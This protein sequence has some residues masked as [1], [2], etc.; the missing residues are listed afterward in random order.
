MCVCLICVL[1]RFLFVFV[2]SSKSLILL[3]FSFCLSISFS[4]FHDELINE[5][6]FHGL[7][8]VGS[9]ASS[10]LSCYRWPMKAHPAYIKRFRPLAYDCVLPRAQWFDLSCSFAWMKWLLISLYI[11]LYILCVVCFVLVYFF[12]HI[13]FCLAL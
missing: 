13:I 8:C 3:H 2:V 9:S 6:E 12:F 7:N 5:P 4:H 11:H 1:S 10:F